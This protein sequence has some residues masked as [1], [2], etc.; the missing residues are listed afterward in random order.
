MEEGVVEPPSPHPTRKRATIRRSG[1]SQMLRGLV[2]L[3][4]SL[5]RTMQESLPDDFG[6]VS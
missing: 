1:R 2:G 3:D 5:I 6:G 4:R